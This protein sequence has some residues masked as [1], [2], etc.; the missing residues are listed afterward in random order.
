M[1]LL[2]APLRSGLLYMI[3]IKLGLSLNNPETFLLLV[4]LA[5]SS[6]VKLVRNIFPSSGLI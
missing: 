2:W 5:F 3:N 1:D 4:Q 6:Q